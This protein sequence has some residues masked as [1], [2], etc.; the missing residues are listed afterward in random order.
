VRQGTKPGGEGGITRG[1]PE[2]FHVFRFT[3]NL[4]IPGDVVPVTLVIPEVTGGQE[5]A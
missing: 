3:A 1:L 2:S 5:S 4:M